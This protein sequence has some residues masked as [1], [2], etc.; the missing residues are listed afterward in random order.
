MRLVLEIAGTEHTFLDCR[1]G[2]QH[3]LQKMLVSSGMWLKGTL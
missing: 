2:L 3:F 1:F